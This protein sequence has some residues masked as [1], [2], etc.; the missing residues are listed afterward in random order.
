MVSADNL[1]TLARAGVKYIVCMPIHRGSEVANEALTRPGRYQTVAE[2]LEV[3]EVT[4][5]D[6]ERCRRYV[7]C[8]TA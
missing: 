1:S 3:K 6:G 2:N 5:G 7:V 8:Y 4:V